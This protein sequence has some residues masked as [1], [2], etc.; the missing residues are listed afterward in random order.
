MP[1]F[2]YYTQIAYTGD[3]LN[4]TAAKQFFGPLLINLFNL[5]I[6][7]SH[8]FFFNIVG[9]EAETDQDPQQV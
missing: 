6:Y 9:F 3:W 5:R 7:I 1:V 8:I 2:L 4:D